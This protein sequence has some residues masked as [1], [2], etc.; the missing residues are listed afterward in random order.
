[1]CGQVCGNFNVCFFAPSL[2]ISILAFASSTHVTV[3]ECAGN[4]CLLARLPTVC[5]VFYTMFCA[6]DCSC[7]CVGKCVFG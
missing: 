5:V 6:H 3:Q 7:V 1:M 4:V 2:Y